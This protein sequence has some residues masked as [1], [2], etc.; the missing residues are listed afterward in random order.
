VARLLHWEQSGG[1]PMRFRYLF[2]IAAF[3]IA[4]PATA[5]A[6]FGRPGPTPGYRNGYERGLTAGTDD[7]HH[8]D[9]YNY[10]DERDYIR[11]DGSYRDDYGRRD[12]YRD[13][14]RRG[15][16]SGYRIGY[17]GPGTGRGRGGYG[18]NDSS[19]WNRDD[20]ARQN[21]FEDGLEAGQKDFRGSRR[22]EPFSEGRYRS[23]DHGYKS[24]YGT[25]DIYRSRYRDAFVEGYRRGYGW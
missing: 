6:Q 3:A 25:K 21:G 10:R 19:Y 20:L 12:V 16:E 13:E 4:A 9:R 23:G 22:Y 7:R 5:S 18:G 14:F 15:F 24:W 2:L 17:E 1:Y 11:A 8:G